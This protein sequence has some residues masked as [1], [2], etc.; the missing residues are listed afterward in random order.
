MHTS[1]LTP[2]VSI[3]ASITFNEPALI[4]LDNRIFAWIICI[5]PYPRIYKCRKGLQDPHPLQTPLR[6]PLRTSIFWKL[7]ELNVFKFQNNI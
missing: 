7:S 4:S 5:T 1:A 2:T 3:H 6:G